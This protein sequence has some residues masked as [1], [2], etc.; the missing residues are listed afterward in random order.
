MYVS[1]CQFVPQR[2]CGRRAQTMF[3]QNGCRAVLCVLRPGLSVG[4]RVPDTNGYLLE[5]E[6]ICIPPNDPALLW[7]NSVSA[8]ARVTKTGRS[9]WGHSTNTQ[10]KHCGQY[11]ARDKL[12]IRDG[13]I[14]GVNL[15]NSVFHG[16]GNHVRRVAVRELV[17]ERG[18]RSKSLSVKCDREERCGTNWLVETENVHTLVPQHTF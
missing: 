1:I 6:V 7:R 9:I 14:H 13:Q 12:T 11:S 15:R 2:H 3:V 16:A 18:C 4:S 10:A 8:S 17:V 5:V